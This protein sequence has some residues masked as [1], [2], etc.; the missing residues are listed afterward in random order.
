MALTRPVLLPVSAFDATQPQ[1]FI[2]TVPGVSTQIIA[3]QLTVRNQSDNS[4]VYQEKFETFKYEHEMNADE[5]VNGNYYNATLS[6]FDSDGNQSPESIPIQFYCYTT[7]TLSF[8]NLPVNNIIQNSSYN[9]EFTYNQNE[10]ESLNTY[11]V[12]LYNVA[13]SVISSSSTQ[14]VQD[15]TPPYSNSYLIT[16]LENATTYSIEVVGTTI[17]GTIISTGLANF[18]VQYLRPDIFTLVELTNN[19]DEGYISIRSNIVSIEGTSNPDPP[20]FIGDTEVDLTESDSWV[21]WNQG[22][23][24]NGDFIAKLWFRNPSV[25]TQILEFSNIAG[26]TIQLYYREG[27]EN[28]NSENMQSY[29]EVFVNSVENNSYYI[30]SN[31]IDTLEETQY[32]N[33]W[34]TRENN[35]YQIQLASV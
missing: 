5:L 19:C 16:G 10:Q 33:F 14:Y 3:N 30:F 12:N 13:G 2:F 6:V 11:V 22:Y 32:Y 20:V 8:T 25:N 4:I 35:I 21:E 34:L 28:V 7:P 27:Y 1:T 9:F 15:G 17:N 24:I 26:Q 31:F 23:R 29:I 18:T